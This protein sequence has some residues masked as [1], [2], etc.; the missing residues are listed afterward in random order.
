V[1]QVLRVVQAQAGCREIRDYRGKTVL[2]A[3]KAIRARKEIP[4]QQARK[5]YQV[6]RAIKV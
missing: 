2:P 1:Q 6:A 3:P 5:V 4:A